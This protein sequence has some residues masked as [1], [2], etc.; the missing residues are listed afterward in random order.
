VLRVARVALVVV[1]LACAGACGHGGASNGGGQEGGAQDGGSLDGSAT[2]D[3]S[4][5]GDG[6]PPPAESGP[7]AMVTAC[8]TLQTLPVRTPTY[9]VDFAAG[10]DMADGKSQATAFQH[11]PGDASA[12]GNA[13]ST[14]LAPGDVVLLKG[15]VAYEGTIT[16][17]ASGTSAAPIVLEGGAQEAWGSGMAIVDGANTRSLGIGVQDASYVVVEGFE[18]RS[19][20]KAQS[21]TGISGD[22]GG[23]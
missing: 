15:G 22:G 6:P 23:V 2:L 16:L 14:M 10:S 9:Y 7:P 4:G 11:A 20:D 13:Q 12:T 21:S 19:F 18:V 1:A 8:S 5:Q 3:G 17:T